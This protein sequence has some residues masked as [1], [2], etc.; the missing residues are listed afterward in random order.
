MVGRNTVS[1][2][3]PLTESKD[4]ALS[5][6]KFWL[7]RDLYTFNADC[8]TS[9]ELGSEETAS[10]ALNNVN[11]FTAS[12]DDILSRMGKVCLLRSLVYSRLAWVIMCI[13]I[14][15]SGWTGEG[16]TEFWS[17]RELIL[18]WQSLVNTQGTSY[19]RRKAFWREVWHRAVR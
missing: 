16:V 6:Q 15:E 3:Y 12:A 8:I 2:F 5:C 1:S 4:S 18:K 9:Y 17:K 13:I 14:W 7:G 11:L 19:S 10:L